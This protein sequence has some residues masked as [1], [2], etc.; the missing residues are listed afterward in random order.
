VPGHGCDGAAVLFERNGEMVCR[1]T[2]GTNAPELGTR[3]DSE[4]GLTAECVRTQQVQH[5]DDAQADPRANLEAS[6][7][8]GHGR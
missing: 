4:S 2:C 5:C 6:H 7:E 8:L 1:A 3:L